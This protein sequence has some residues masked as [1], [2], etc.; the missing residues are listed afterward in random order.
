MATTATT[1]ALSDVLKRLYRPKVR[2][3]LNN[4]ILVLQILNL[5]TEDLEGL[6][7]VMALHT[8]RS[9]GIGAR[10]ELADLPAAGVQKYKQA[11][12]DLA[13]LYGRIQVSGQAISKTR[14]DAG[15]WIRAMREELDRVR[16]D[17][18]L[19]FARQVYGNGD[20]II[21]KVA[22]VDT[23]GDPDFVILT[24]DEAL[25]KGFI[26]AGMHVDFG[27]SSTSINHGTDIEVLDVDVANKKV[28]FTN[29]TIASVLANDFIFRSGANDANGTAEMNAGLQSLISD[30]P[31][32]GVIG[33]IDP[34]SNFFW[35]N[36]AEDASDA[37]DSGA[38]SL[39]LLMQ[40][41]N[42]INA[43]GAKAGNIKM[44]STP[45]LSR[46]LFES[47]D[48]VQKVQFVNTKTFGA[49]F[50]SLSFSA[51]A[52]N[53]EL[54]SDRLAPYGKV[55]MIDGGHV[56]FFSPGDWD[57]LARDGLA[58]KWVDN[59]DAFQSILFRYVNMGTDRRNTSAVIFGLTDTGF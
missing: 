54:V 35:R 26:Y 5:N 28:T 42:R 57:F 10:R 23:S 14:S 17:L 29:G 45:G 41:Y 1:T 4:E 56:E 50:E 43:Q 55:Y 22:S 44:L 25:Q 12:Y 47:A 37:P 19:D 13:Y 33:N 24:S 2:E 20:G 3:Q 21:A 11:E 15:S 18:A 27:V 8:G 31:G 53:L 59:K 48:F 9:T 51:G 38:I 30:T 6:K 49:G 39:S 34:A 52:G 16:D 58:V 40:V 7:A 36:H 32:T 46:R